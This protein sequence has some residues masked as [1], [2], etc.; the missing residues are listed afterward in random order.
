MVVIVGFA[1]RGIAVAVDRGSD[2]TLVRAQSLDIGHPSPSRDPDAE[3][4]RDA[5]PRI[6]ICFTPPDAFVFVPDET[7]GTGPIDRG[8]GCRARRYGA[9]SRWA[10]SSLASSAA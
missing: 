8:Q 2:R 6:R 5:R 9:L 3:S 10:C 7:A 4:V 1:G